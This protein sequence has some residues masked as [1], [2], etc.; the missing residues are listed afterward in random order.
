MMCVC[1]QHVRPQT[2][3]ATVSTVRGDRTA[4]TGSEEVTGQQLQEEKSFR[5]GC[6]TGGRRGFGGVGA[7]PG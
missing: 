4:S 7:G 3:V 2:T 5:T 6:P 1:G